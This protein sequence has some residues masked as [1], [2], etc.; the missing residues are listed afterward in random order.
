VKTTTTPLSDLIVTTQIAGWGLDTSRNHSAQSFTN[1][2][3]VNYVDGGS[4]QYCGFCDGTDPLKDGL[5]TYFITSKGNTL[6]SIVLDYGSS[7]AAKTEFDYWVTFSNDT[8]GEIPKT[9]SPFSDTTAV[10]YYGGGGV[11]AYAHFDNYF[12]EFDVAK[13]YDSSGQAVP[14]AQAFLNYYS[15]KIK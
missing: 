13:N 15:S 9:I 10:G 2:T 5:C 14:D 8:A 7:S 12:L 3:A 11:T 1:A 6:K 4:K